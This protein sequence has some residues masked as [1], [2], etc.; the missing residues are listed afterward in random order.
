MEDEATL[1][2][3]AAVTGIAFVV[4]LLVIGTVWFFAWLISLIVLVVLR[5]FNPSHPI[6]AEED[7]D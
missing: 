7:I 4:L 3:L 2:G 5:A 6:V 1:V